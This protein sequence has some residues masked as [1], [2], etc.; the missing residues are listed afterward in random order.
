MAGTTKR[1]RLAVQLEGIQE[2][3]YHSDMTSAARVLRVQAVVGEQVV[4]ETEPLPTSIR[5]DDAAAFVVPLELDLDAEKEADAAG[6]DEAI[7]AGW[8][9][10]DDTMANDYTGEEVQFRVLRADTG[11]VLG[12]AMSTKDALRSSQSLQVL[13][14]G[15]L[16]EPWAMYTSGLGTESSTHKSAPLQIPNSAILDSSGGEAFMPSTMASR[17]TESPFSG[18]ELSRRRTMSMS[19]IS[20]RPSTWKQRQRPTALHVYPI[21]QDLS[22]EP[23]HADGMLSIALET[24]GVLNTSSFH[25]GGR[26]GT[27]PLV[28]QV[29]RITAERGRAPEANAHVGSIMVMRSRAAGLPQVSRPVDFR[30]AQ[31]EEGRT[32]TA[33]VLLELLILSET[34]STVVGVTESTVGQLRRLVPGDRVSLHPPRVDSGAP[35]GHISGTSG[36]AHEGTSQPASLES[37]ETGFLTVRANSDNELVMDAFYYANK[38]GVSRDRSPRSMPRQGEHNIPHSPTL[39]LSS[40]IGVGNAV[41]DMARRTFLSRRRPNAN[42]NPRHAP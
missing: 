28:L 1:L 39:S 16:Y 11:Q 19:F 2:L 8:H 38:R 35:K 23:N 15:P 41:S 29:S 13:Q 30:L 14:H 4:S 12:T 20:R 36:G 5:V 27:V 7:S 40:A 42:A 31:D 22:L 9:V 17:E 26:R 10:G 21:E 25:S 33:P 24:R 32:A 34:G 37:E 18:I 6:E 3:A